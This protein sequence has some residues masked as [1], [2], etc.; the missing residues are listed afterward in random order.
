MYYYSGVTKLK[1]KGSVK[2]KDMTEDMVP[3]ELEN[4][5][6]TARVGET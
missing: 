2:F 3:K 5:R 4:N 1:G 6:I